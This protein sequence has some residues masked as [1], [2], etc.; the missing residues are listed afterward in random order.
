MNN[1]L[2][3]EDIDRQL[4]IMGVG[5]KP[6]STINVET[7]RLKINKLGDWIIKG[8]GWQSY[9]D[10]RKNDYLENNPSDIT[11]KKN[12]T[13]RTLGI[14]K[15]E[16][17]ITDR[18]VERVMDRMDEN[19]LVYVEGEW[20][21][22][23]KVNTNYSQALSIISKVLINHKEEVPEI[24]DAMDGD[25]LDIKKVLIKHKEK[26]YGFI[27]KDYPNFEDFFDEI[28]DVKR[29]SSVGQKFEDDV[30]SYLKNKHY[31]IIHIGGDGDFIDMVL[32]IDVAFRN[33]KNA[34]I[35]L[36]IKNSKSGAVSFK[37]KDYR[38]KYINYIIYN[39]RS[40][41]RSIK[42]C[43]INDDFTP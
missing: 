7:L 39:E 40:R 27:D 11:I 24:M 31:E 41:K 15:G 33:E 19:S 32:G 17:V 23:N 29:S 26:I 38:C 8:F 13:I 20:H 14:L 4:D 35:T 3:K 42:G 10:D 34:I 36:Q 30:V 9:F 6:S 37:K 21:L 2:L 28:E 25:L 43:R 22:V 5:N 1:K 16:G 12:E 18:D